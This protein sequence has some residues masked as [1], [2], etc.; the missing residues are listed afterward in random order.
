[1]AIDSTLGEIVL[2]D[3]PT[4]SLTI[5]AG[6][7]DDT[8]NINGVR[9]TFAASLI[10]N[11]GVGHDTVNLNNDITFAANRNLDV[12]L[13]NDDAANPGI[14]RIAVPANANYVLSG[15]GTATLKASSSISFATGSSLITADG[16]LLLEANGPGTGDATFTGI[17]VDGATVQSTGSGAVQ[18]LGRGG[19]GGSNNHGV[20]LTGAAVIQSGTGPLQVT[21]TGGISSTSPNLG[22]LVEGPGALISSAGGNVR[23]TGIGGGTGVS[24]RQHRRAHPQ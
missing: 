18:I 7:G 16:V 24:S 3:N 15:T 22:V 8:V 11:G 2:F 5:D 6:T 4:N 21:G 10:I 1:M 20:R 14:D 19:V 23:V 17:T 9:P 12:D 13:Q